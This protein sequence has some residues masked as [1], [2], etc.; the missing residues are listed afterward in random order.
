MNPRFPLSELFGDA[1]WSG[2][3]NGLAWPALFGM[4]GFCLIGVLTLWNYATPRPEA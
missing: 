3:G 2:G 1:A 4:G